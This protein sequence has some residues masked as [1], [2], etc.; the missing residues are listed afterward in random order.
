MQKIV[1]RYLVVGRFLSVVLQPPSTEDVIGDQAIGPEPLSNVLPETET[2]DSGVRSIRS[3]QPVGLAAIRLSLA[4]GAG[5]DDSFA[6]GQVPCWQSCGA[7]AMINFMVKISVWLYC[8]RDLI[9]RLKK[10]PIIL[11]YPSLR[12][13]NMPL[14]Q[15]NLFAEL[16]NGSLVDPDRFVLAQQACLGRIISRAQPRAWYDLLRQNV[17]EQLLGDAYIGPF[18]IQTR[19]VIEQYDP[20]TLAQF[21]QRVLSGS[22]LIVSVYG[23]YDGAA[24]QAKALHQSFASG[25]QYV[26]EPLPLRQLTVWPEQQAKRSQVIVDQ[27]GGLN[28]LA[29]VYR[30]VSADAALQRRAASDVLMAILGDESGAGLWLQSRLE[31]GGTRRLMQKYR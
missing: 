23:D 13:R 22:R 16:I 25:S 17:R 2:F 7:A 12:C 10:L 31:L 28:A 19:E 6:R 5:L 1:R 15:L 24:V 21:H 27:E 3:P 18:T 11:H 26:V 14:Q 8:V 20:V 9:T 29:M 30:G 4:A